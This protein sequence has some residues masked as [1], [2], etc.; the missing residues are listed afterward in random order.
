MGIGRFFL[1]IYGGY[2][3]HA[4]LICWIYSNTESVLMAQFMHVSSTGSLI[5]FGAPGRRRPRSVLVRSLWNY[6]VGR[7]RDH[8]EDLWQAYDATDCLI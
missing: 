4:G 2:D 3:C 7:G 6:V 5:I 8:C 1:V